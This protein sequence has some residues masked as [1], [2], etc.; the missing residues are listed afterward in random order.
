MEV[1][2][3]S[4]KRIIS[5]TNILLSTPIDKEMKSHRNDPVIRKKKER[6]LA[7]LGKVKNLHDLL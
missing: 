4:N 5:E 2:K 3:K 1:T 6:A 7:M